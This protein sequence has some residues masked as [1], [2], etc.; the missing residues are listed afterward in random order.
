VPPKCLVPKVVGKRLA[1]AKTKIR[2][3]HCS[4]GK[5]T[6]KHA[7]ASKHGKVISQSPKPGRRLKNHAK[8]NLTVGK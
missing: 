1:V 8:V 4:V 2:K 7:S 3:A 6:R 5:I